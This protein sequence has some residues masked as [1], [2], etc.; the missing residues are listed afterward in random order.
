MLLSQPNYVSPHVGFSAKLCF[1]A[2]WFLSKLFLLMLVSQQN[3]TSPQFGHANNLYVFLWF[4]TAAL[5]PKSSPP[6]R[7]DGDNRLA[8]S[9]AVNQKS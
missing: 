8:E 6:L 3:N 7:T 4:F 9:T 1:P 2:C 5:A